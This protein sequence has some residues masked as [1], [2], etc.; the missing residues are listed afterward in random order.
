MCYYTPKEI[1]AQVE[2][3]R[4]TL[5]VG[6]QP[7]AR[8]QSLVNEQSMVEAGTSNLILPPIPPY[9]HS[10]IEITRESGLAS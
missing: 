1:Q 10:Q 5:F 2:K 4:L 3:S 7:D 6:T 9:S 8:W